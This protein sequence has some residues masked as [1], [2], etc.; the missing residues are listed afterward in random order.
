[1]L[2]IFEFRWFEAIVER[3]LNAYINF[4]FLVM[5]AHVIE[6]EDLFVDFYTFGSLLEQSQIVIK[7]FQSPL[8]ILHM[9]F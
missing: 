6:V 8:F 3:I 1:M 9:F 2:L 4:L 5:W 7:I